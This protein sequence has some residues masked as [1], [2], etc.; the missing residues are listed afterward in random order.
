MALLIKALF[1]LIKFFTLIL[2]ILVI[3]IAGWIWLRRPRLVDMGSYVPADAKVYIEANNFPEIVRGL[4]STSVISHNTPRDESLWAKAF[5]AS[6]ASGAFGAFGPW[7]DRIMAWSG[8]G[9]AESVIFSRAQL[10]IYVSGFEAS[11]NN[12]SI[13]LQPRICI[14]IETHTDESRSQRVFEKYSGDLINALLPQPVLKKTERD[15]AH[16]YYWTATGNRR[17]IGVVKGSLILISN[18]E[19]VVQACLDV[20]RQTRPSLVNNPEFKEMRLRAQTQ[21]S[22][23]LGFATSE[24]SSQLA[25]AG[26]LTTTSALVSS[27]DERRLIVG[28]ASQL[29]DNA[30]KNIAWSSDFSDSLIEDNYYVTLNKVAAAHLSSLQTSADNFAEFKKASEILPANI[31][32]ATHYNYLE[33][34]KLWRSLN[35]AIATQLETFSAIAVSSFLAVAAKPYGIDSPD[36]FLAALG[37]GITTS[38][39]DDQPES[40]VI[41]MSVQ[42]EKLLRQLLAARLGPRPQN[43]RIGNIEMQIARGKD[44]EAAAFFGEN[45]GGESDLHLIFG[46]SENVRA[47]LLARKNNHTLAT[48]AYLKNFDATVSNMI[49]AHILTISNETESTRQLLSRLA[50]SGLLDLDAASN[51]MSKQDDMMA[52]TSTRFL[53]EGIE[54]QTLSPLGRYGWLAEMLLERSN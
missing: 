45:S 53:T 11:T 32:S 41:I 9:P 43:E 29:A 8:V 4:Y 44:S 28:I 47:C 36:Q 14:L 12:E 54:R 10:A 6:G 52:I 49:P 38:Q 42:N 2:L 22:A 7:L 27:N 24:G 51:R 46:L 30:I 48:S 37:P 39:L 1:K 15:Q 21:R 33:P 35:S 31:H 16:Y 20:N 19:S 5:G 3:A 40:T 50:S 26:I 17:I 18:N 25:Q 13:E 23:V 34:Q